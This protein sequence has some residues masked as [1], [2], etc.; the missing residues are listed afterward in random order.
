M[1]NYK[2]LIVSINRFKTILGKIFKNF[3]I[4]CNQNLM[5]EFEQI[6]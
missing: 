2:S 1:I 6:Y 3:A 4:A 5:A